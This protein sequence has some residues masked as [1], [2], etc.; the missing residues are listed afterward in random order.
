M[1]VYGINKSGPDTDKTY[2]LLYSNK[3]DAIKALKELAS[4]ENILVSKMYD[5][6]DEM[7][8]LQEM[9]FKKKSDECYE[10]ILDKLEIVEF[11]VR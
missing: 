10:T 5:E 7:E 6:P 9:T 8:D 2:N 11:T 4:Y 3:E 1:I